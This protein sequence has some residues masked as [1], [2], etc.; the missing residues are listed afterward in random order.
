[1]DWRSPNTNRGEHR[2]R[3][4][5]NQ[6]QGNRECDPRLAGSQRGRP[7]M[8]RYH[9]HPRPDEAGGRLRA[10]ASTV[11]A[12]HRLV[13]LGEYPAAARLVR[14]LKADAAV[15]MVLLEDL[16][17][18]CSSFLNYDNASDDAGRLESFASTM[19]GGQKSTRA[20]EKIQY[21]RW[22]DED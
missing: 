13:D 3:T 10:W 4:S 1:M 2:E 11:R 18:N 6:E 9:P 5:T 8:D 7:S 16:E 17:E 14:G 12:I 20:V 19:P 15:F 22:G 21:G